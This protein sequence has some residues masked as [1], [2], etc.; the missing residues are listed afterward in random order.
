MAAIA[1][2]AVDVFVLVFALLLVL[3][4][5]VAAA[6][7]VVV[8]AAVVA[9]VVVG[10]AVPEAIGNPAGAERRWARFGRGSSWAGS[11]LP[12]SAFGL[13]RG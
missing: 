8:A 2:P 11:W 1:V 3:D 10:F 5:V 4:V 6:A 7:A 13:T 9:V 12:L